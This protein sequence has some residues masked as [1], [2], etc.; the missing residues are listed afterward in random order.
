MLVLQ[1]VILEM[2]GDGRKRGAALGANGQ[3][4]FIGLGQLTKGIA[5]GIDIDDIA[6]LAIDLGDD[7]I[8]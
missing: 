3:A 5:V 8:G 7:L 6:A 2:I 4:A 1:R